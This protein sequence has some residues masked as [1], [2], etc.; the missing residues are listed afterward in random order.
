MGKKLK[1]RIVDRHGWK[2]LEVREN[3]TANNLKAIIEGEMQ[4]LGEFT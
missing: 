3:L 2:E 1:L 4:A